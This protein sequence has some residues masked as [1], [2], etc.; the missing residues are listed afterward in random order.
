MQEAPDG[1]LP[2]A[3]KILHSD[4]F[5]DGE[6]IC[7]AEN[8]FSKQ[9]WMRIISDATKVLVFICYCL[10]DL[11]RSIR[12]VL[13]SEALIASFKAKG[14]EL[15]RQTKQVSEQLKVRM[16]YCWVVDADMTD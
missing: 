2:F 11:F 15:Q 7:A 9:E 13:M 8:E 14:E 3:F 5:G 16:N 10:S 1:G 12:T 6:I 4:A